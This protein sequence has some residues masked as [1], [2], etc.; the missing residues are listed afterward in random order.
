LI[1]DRCMVPQ[2][3]AHNSGPQFFYELRRLNHAPTHEYTPL[4]SQRVSSSSSSLWFLNTHKWVIWSTVLAIWS[5]VLAIW[6]TVVLAAH[7]HDQQVYQHAYSAYA[8]HIQWLIHVP[9]Y[10]TLFPLLLMISSIQDC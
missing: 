10:V 3:L 8:A 9:L 1:G 2:F 5:T 7:S 6:S 4:M